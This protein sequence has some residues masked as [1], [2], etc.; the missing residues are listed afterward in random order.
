MEC[1]SNDEDRSR[2]KVTVWKDLSTIRLTGLDA[3]CRQQHTQAA[4]PG[5]INGGERSKP[6]NVD[7]LPAFW[8]AL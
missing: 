2:W 8:S 7:A 1:I 5:R 3:A 4:G 6:A